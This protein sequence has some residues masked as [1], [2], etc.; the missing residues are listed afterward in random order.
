MK[1]SLTA[2]LACGF[3]AAQEPQPKQWTMPNHPPLPYRWSAPAK[4][5][6]DATYPLV[7]FLHGAGE[8]GSDNTA[9]LKHGVRAILKAAEKLNQPCFLIAPQC[10]PDRWWTPRGPRANDQHHNQAPLDAVIALV[11]DTLKRHPVDPARVYVTGLSMGGYGTWHLLAS[12][13]DLFAAAIPICGGGD[14]GKA[15][16]FKAVPIW[17]FHGE[18]DPVVPVKTTREMIAAL[19]QAGGK[20][21]ATY[22]PGVAHDSWTATYDNTEVLKWLFAQRKGE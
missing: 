2:L 12:Q 5:E 11:T 21:K 6:P 17:A 14:P 9:Q 18:A 16:S 4:M 20:P 13:P 3:A 10:P 7:L 19:E 8:R 15:V 22:Y 1:T